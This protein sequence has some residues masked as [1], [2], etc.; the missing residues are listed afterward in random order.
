MS[1][2]YDSQNITSFTPPCKVGKYWNISLLARLACF[3]AFLQA[4][5]DSA[6]L[7]NDDYAGCTSANTADSTEIHFSISSS[8][9]D[10]GRDTNGVKL[11]G[12]KQKISEISAADTSLIISSLR[13][14]GSAS[15]EGSANYNQYRVSRAKLEGFV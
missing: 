6:A 4:A 11:E 5:F 2:S 8:G 15:P 9:L 3:V 14:V 10:F 1:K 12:L 13:I 7:Q